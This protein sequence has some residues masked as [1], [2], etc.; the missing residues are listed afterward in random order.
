M[1]LD[2]GQCPFR[3]TGPNGRVLGSGKEV[4]VANLALHSMLSTMVNGERRLAIDSKRT[5]GRHRIR[6]QYALSKEETEPLTTPVPGG[7]P[8]S[9]HLTPTRREEV[10]PLGRGASPTVR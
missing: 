3:D 6:A 5:N 7:S 8:A 4:N 1:W 9:P 2:E 10:A